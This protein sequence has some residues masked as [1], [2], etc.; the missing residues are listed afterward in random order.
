MLDGLSDL[1]RF[2]GSRKA[3]GL[4]RSR[5]GIKK[6]IPEQIDFPRRQL[7]TE[8]PQMMLV[9]VPAI[10]IAV[11][12][13][14]V[15]DSPDITEK[16]HGFSPW[17]L[18]RCRPGRFLERLRLLQVLHG[19]FELGQQVIELVTNA[20][21]HGESEHVARPSDVRNSVIGVRNLLA[22]HPV[23]FRRAERARPNRATDRDFMP[24]N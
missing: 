18:E 23:D 9:R 11:R 3:N 6:T 2:E 15:S 10:L 17:T 19:V 16:R 1:D 7:T 12:H 8:K 21:L 4:A 20:V 5:P 22:T 13:L 14:K 24:S